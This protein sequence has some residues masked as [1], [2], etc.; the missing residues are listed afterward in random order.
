MV[1][2]LENLSPRESW[3]PDRWVMTSQNEQRPL[4]SSWMTYPWWIWPS[5]SSQRGGRQTGGSAASREGQVCGG[6]GWAAKKEAIISAEGRSKAVEL[7]A[8]SLATAAAGDGLIQLLK[9]EAAKGMAEELPRPRNITYLPAGQSGLLLLPQWRSHLLGHLDH[10]PEDVQHH[11]PSTAPEN[12]VKLH[13]WL[14]VKKI[15]V[16]SLQISYSIGLSSLI[17]LISIPLFQ[18]TSIPKIAKCLHRPALLLSLGPAGTPAQ[19]LATGR[20]KAGLCVWQAGS[21]QV[22]L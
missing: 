14:K 22:N 8:N 4:G 10:S 11:L 6:K 17:L 13:D 3:P 1:A 9:G 18:F 7:I 16:K 20:R 12:T 5:G 15:K 2:R 19:A 21:Q